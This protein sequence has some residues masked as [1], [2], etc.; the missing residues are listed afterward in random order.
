M[1]PALMVSA[2]ILVGLVFAALGGQPKVGFAHRRRAMVEDQIVA[3]GIRD[4]RVLAAMRSV[5]REFFVPPEYRDRA[6]DDSPVP[7]GQGQTISQPYIVALMTQTLGLKKGDKVL[8]IGTGSGYQAAI[9]SRL[10]ALV[11]SIEINASLA[12]R[13]AST[14]EG[15][16]MANVRIR[17]GD[18]FFG[19]PEEAPF[20]A[21]VVTCAVKDVP[22]RLLAQLAEGGRMVVPLGDPGSYQIL[23]LIVKKKGR[24]V[25]HKILDVR[26]VPMTGEALKKK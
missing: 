19:W 14:L 13:A 22:P 2:S 23:T 24:P 6:Y 21:V 5:P 10:A 18:G 8:E 16:G 3:R 4:S 26:F 15:L 25:V 7:I 9:L 17:T 20:D 12:A 1:R 11:F